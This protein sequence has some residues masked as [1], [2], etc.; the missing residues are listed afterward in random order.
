VSWKDKMKYVMDEMTERYN[1]FRDAKLKLI[2]DF[3]EIFQY[4]TY[5]VNK[6]DYTGNSVTGTCTDG[7]KKYLL[8]NIYT[9]RSDLNNLE[10]AVLNKSFAPEKLSQIINIK[11]KY[12]WKNNMQLQDIIKKE[13]DVNV[14]DIS[15][16][17][18]DAMALK[19]NSPKYFGIARINYDSGI[20]SQD[21]K[22]EFIHAYTSS[23]KTLKEVSQEFEKKYGMHI[24]SSTISK[25]ARKYLRS[26]GLEFKNRK[27][28]KRYYAGF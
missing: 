15:S 9:I 6:L 16:L 19:V 13:I 20:A 4:A 27:E 1:Y 7:N 26:K 3:R 25:N 2:G 23:E 22:E 21:M 14:P 10:D 11:N 5:S 17:I 12:F 28:A 24:S 18:R 8:R